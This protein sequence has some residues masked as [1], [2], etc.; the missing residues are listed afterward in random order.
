MPLRSSSSPRHREIEEALVERLLPVVVGREIAESTPGSSESMKLLFCF[1]F[2]FCSCAF[3]R[4]HFRDGNDV[5]EAL[6]NPGIRYFSV[7]KAAAWNGKIR[8][9][10]IGH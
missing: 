9:S 5:S 6:V 4:R 8:A 2:V 10:L 7:K 3:Y 1:F